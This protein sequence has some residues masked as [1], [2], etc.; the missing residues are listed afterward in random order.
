MGGW[1]FEQFLGFQ[2]LLAEEGVIVDI[3]EVFEMAIDLAIQKKKDELN[4][5]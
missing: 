5:A 4:S 2:R 1:V 3:P